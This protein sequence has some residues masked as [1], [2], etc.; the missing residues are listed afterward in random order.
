MTLN[1]EA[2]PFQTPT[3]TLYVSTSKNALLQTAQGIFYNPKKPSSILKV[4]AVLDTGSQRSYVTDTVKKALEL[5]LKKVQQ[6][7]IAAFRTST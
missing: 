1:P 5:E 4:R 2:P 6:L 7:S 3:S